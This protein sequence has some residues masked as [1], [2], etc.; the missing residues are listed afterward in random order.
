MILEHE[1]NKTT[2]LFSGNADEIQLNFKNGSYSRR[3]IYT[4]LT[5][6]SERFKIKHEKAL[7]LVCIFSIYRGLYIYTRVVPEVRRLLL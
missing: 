6:S 5:D 2:L 4:G 3:C 1:Q 7:F